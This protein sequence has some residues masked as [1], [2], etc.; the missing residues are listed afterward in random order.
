[1]VGINVIHL[2]D[3]MK[4]FFGQSEFP[5]WSLT[6]HHPN[7]FP[8]WKKS[9]GVWAITLPDISVPTPQ[10]AKLSALLFI[11]NPVTHLWISASP[12]VK[13]YEK[14]SQSIMGPCG[15]LEPSLGAELQCESPNVVKAAIKNPAGGAS[16]QRGALM[17]CLGSKSFYNF[18]L[19]FQWPQMKM[20][21]ERSPWQQQ[22]RK[23]PS[24]ALALC[25]SSCFKGEAPSGFDYLDH[26]E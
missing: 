19:P 1:M 24:R 26:E 10:T 11:Q 8:V 16:E 14:V 3:K 9:P 20:N 17:T 15:G 12:P 2:Y 5:C 25:P 23:Q 7:I 13:V 21:S 22:R 6:P 18:I 4:N